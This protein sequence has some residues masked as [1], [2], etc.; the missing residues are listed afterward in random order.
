ME[1]VDIA[2]PFSVR[3]VGKDT[4]HVEFE[5]DEASAGKVRAL[6]ADIVSPGGVDRIRSPHRTPP[7]RTD[8]VLH[9]PLK[10]PQLRKIRKPL[11]PPHSAAPQLCVSSRQLCGKARTAAGNGEEAGHAKVEQP[12]KGTAYLLHLRQVTHCRSERPAAAAAN[13]I[14][15]WDPAGVSSS[16]GG[17]FTANTIHGTHNLY[18]VGSMMN[19]YTVN[20]L[21]Q[22]NGFHAQRRT[23]RRAWP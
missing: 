23:G 1:G 4:L 6:R 13:T 22:I 8:F 3:A 5:L 2:V 18:D 21:E 20:F 17:A 10:T 15:T 9:K 12:V 11:E 7:V 16:L 19:T 14:F